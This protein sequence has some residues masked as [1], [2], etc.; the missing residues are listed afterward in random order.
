MNYVSRPPG[1]SAWYWIF[2]LLPPHT[3][4]QVIVDRPLGQAGPRSPAA[5]DKT[6]PTG[7]HFKKKKVCLFFFHFGCLPVGL[8]A[9]G[10]D[11]SCLARG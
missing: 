4:N 10:L 1:A 7:K 11:V 6:K 8:M 3:S 9:S 5:K 2:S